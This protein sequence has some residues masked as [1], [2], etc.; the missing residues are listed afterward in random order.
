MNSICILVLFVG[1]VGSLKLK[2]AP[3]KPT[4]PNEFD[5][6]FSMSAPAGKTFYFVFIQFN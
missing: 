1:L 3:N 6:T 2:D 5:A 4:W